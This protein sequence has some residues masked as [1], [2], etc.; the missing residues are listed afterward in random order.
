MGKEN[1]HRHTANIFFI[2]QSIKTL[3]PVFVMNKDS[4]HAA[5]C[6]TSLCETGLQDILLFLAFTYV[7]LRYGIWM[8]S[9]DANKRRDTDKSVE[10]LT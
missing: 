1:T 7:S 2:A 8:F 6:M 4:S 5:H 3:V 9:P 10:S